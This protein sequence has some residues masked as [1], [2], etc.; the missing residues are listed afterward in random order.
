MR[1]T[2][3]Y[4]SLIVT[5]LVLGAAALLV[6]PID[7]KGEYVHRIARLWAAIHLRVNGIV[8]CS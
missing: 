6:S 4:A 3:S 8:V 2:F 7:P 1:K 5:T